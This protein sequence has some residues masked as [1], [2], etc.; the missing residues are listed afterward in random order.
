MKM[1]VIAVLVIVCAALA[2]DD[3]WITKNIDFVDE[4]SRGPVIYL[5][6]VEHRLETNWVEHFK[7]DLQLGLISSNVTA[8]L[9]YK[10]TNWTL[11]LENSDTGK[12]VWRNTNSLS[13][14]SAE[15]QT[16]KRNE[17]QH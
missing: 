2:A 15:W 1:R 13:R 11:V 3:V 7:G 17:P 12:H 8:W 14:P 9:E 10:G 16:F 4:H 6:R 5:G